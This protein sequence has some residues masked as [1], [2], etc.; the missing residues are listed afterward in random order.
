MGSPSQD[1]DRSSTSNSVADEAA[2]HTLALNPMVGL[3][4][5]DFVDAAR[6]VFKAAISQPGIAVNQWV[7]FLGDVGK[8]VVGEGTRSVEPGDK[9]FSDPAWK[10]SRLH[11]KVLQSYLAWSDALSA[12]VDKV[13]LDERDRA[14]AKLITGM[15]ID[16]LAPT[17]ALLANPAA[18]KRLVDTD[19][20]SLWAGLKNYIEDLIKNGGMPSQV[21]SKPFAVGKN[22]ATTSGAVVFREPVF[23]LIQYKP[24]T[25]QVL[26]RPVVITPP[27]INKYYSLD[28][29]PEKS[30]VRFLLQEG[31]QVFCISWRNP[32]PEQRDWGL[33]TY[34]R[35]V[36]EA[37]DVARAI[38]GSP[39]VSMFGAC[40]GGITG[41]AYVAW[42]AG[43]GHSKVSNLVLAVC[44]LDPSTVEDTT[45]GTLVTPVT[46]EAARKASQTRG[47]LDGRE[48]AKVFAWL[49]P[50][51]LIWNYWVSNYLMGNA[52]PAFDI[53]FWNNDTTA[54]PARLHSDYLDLIETNPFRRAGALSILGTPIDMG[55]VKVDSY[56]VAGTTDHITPWKAVYQT[57]RIL[58]D[59]TTFV[60]SNSGHLQCL[61]NPPGNPKASFASGPAK[62]VN[63]D[64]FA[65][66]AEKQA[67]SW[68]TH[69]SAWLSTRS[70][71]KVA[72]PS[73]LGSERFPPREAAPGTYVF[74]A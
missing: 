25:E 20:E 68:W 42:Q 50:N 36:D 44:T 61:V 35:A 24:L 73:E 70:G 9:R 60:L 1:Q 23:E 29:T 53:L 54:L 43:W 15:L 3:R 7:S 31:F 18:V 27:Q 56:V 41:A 67:G 62:A 39:D 40:S 8:A 5:R 63:P 22:I 19:G 59:E 26:R 49:R 71:E 13:D 17:N 48:L 33:D 21:D 46:I 47:V 38:S 12:F 10:T 55:K 28:L 4:S 32:K 37:V 65:A 51:D 14:R 16:A 45:L 6:T 30:L 58:G 66:T 74:N 57:A 52:P 11:R 34:V 64:R 2:K 72:A 69:W